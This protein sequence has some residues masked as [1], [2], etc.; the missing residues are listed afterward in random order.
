MAVTE[1]GYQN[2]QMWNMHDEGGSA[3]EM[4]QIALSPESNGN[5]ITAHTASNGGMTITLQGQF[6]LNG[7]T[8]ADVTGTL[9]NLSVLQNGREYFSDHYSNGADWQSL[10]RSFDYNL[11]LLSG[12]DAFIGSTTA[13][14][15]DNIQSAGGNDVFAGYGDTR[16]SDGSVGDQFYG[17][18]GVDTAVYR[19]KLA[20]YSIDQ[21]ATIYDARGQSYTPVSGMTVTD[22]VANRD[23]FDKLVD[24]ERMQFSDTNVAF[25]YQSGGHAG[26]AYRLYKGVLGRE[27]EPGGLGYVINRLD[28]GDSLND[29]ASGYLNSPEFQSKYGNTSQSD[30]IN[31]L[32]HNI[33]GRSG[34][35]GGIEY[36]NNWMASGATREDV[37]L[38][39]TESPEYIHQCAELI[40]NNGVHYQPVTSF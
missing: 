18:S 16:T 4:A 26:Q 20:Q 36:I 35:Q 28:H 37:A 17:G 32:Y 25:D 6:S 27:G 1:H 8:L 33:L 11:S 10:I 7:S 34:D 30:F 39:F 38:G 9:T 13:N 31:L 14:I 24:V 15:N 12:D 19:G 2:Y 22:Q 3:A 29:V 40:G 21:H 5:V 23:G